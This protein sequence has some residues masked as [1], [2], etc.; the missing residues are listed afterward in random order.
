ME[1]LSEEEIN[2]ELPIVVAQEI[3]VLIKLGKIAE[4]TEL[5]QSTIIHEYV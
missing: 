1:G 5:A 4:A 3:Y 2:A